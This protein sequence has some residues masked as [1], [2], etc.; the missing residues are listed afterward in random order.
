MEG[1]KFSQMKLI[2]SIHSFRHVF[3]FIYLSIYFFYK[4][5]V[6]KSEAETKRGNAFPSSTWKGKLHCHFSKDTRE[7]VLNFMCSQKGRTVTGASGTDSYI[8][9]FL[10]EMY[11]LWL[12]WPYLRPLNQTFL[13][14]SWYGFGMHFCFRPTS[15]PPPWLQFQISVI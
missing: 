10:K 4:P 15:P 14:F 7:G 11:P 1:K 8:W 13:Q 12:F 5:S 9:R 6:C 3:S 2:H